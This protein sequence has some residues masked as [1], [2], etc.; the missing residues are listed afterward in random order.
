[1]GPSGTRRGGFVR[2]CPRHTA[3]EGS[4]STAPAKTPPS[5]VSLTTVLF[6]IYLHIEVQMQRYSC[7]TQTRTVWEVKMSKRHNLSEGEAKQW[8]K[9]YKI[10]ARKK[11]KEKEDGSIIYRGSA[12]ARLLFVTGKKNAEPHHW[13]PIYS[14]CR[15]V[16]N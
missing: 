12:H 4:F 2:I 9:E 6:L 13:C 15:C 10:N 1:M 3:A 7:L 11:K 8:S 14:R 16:P 5:P